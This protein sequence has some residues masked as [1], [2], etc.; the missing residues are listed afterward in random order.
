MINIKINGRPLRVRQHTTILDAAKAANIK[1]PTLCHLNLHEV[2]YYNSPGNCRVCMV[3]LGNGKLVPACVTQVTEGME[4]FSESVRVIKARRTIIELLLS[5]HP[6]SCLTCEKNT[7]CD[8][9]LLAH[10]LGV[11]EIK[12]KGEMRDHPID[13]HS[14][15]IVRDP[16]K[17]ILCMRCVT[18]CS[19]IQTVGA[20]TASDRGFDSKVGSSFDSPMQETTC[21]FCGQCLSICP[22]GALTEVNNSNQVWNAIADPDKYVV[23]QTAPAV[24]VALGEEFGYEVGTN[25]TGKM[26]AALRNLGVDRVYDTNFAADLTI[27]EEAAEFMRRLENGGTLPMIT[28]CCPSWVNFMEHSFPDMLDNPSSTKSPHEMFGAVA[29]TYLAKKLGIAPEKIYVVSVMP[30]VSKKFEAARDELRDSEL[31]YQVVDNVITTRELARMIKEAGIA[32]EDLPNEDFDELLGESTGAGTIFGATGGVLEATLR[33]CY[34]W[35]TGDDLTLL[36]FESL[37]GFSGVKAA[38]VTINGKELKF[39]V[40]NGLGNTRKVIEKIRAGE[41][42][43]DAIEVMACPG[44]CIGGAG[45]PYHHGDMTIL[46]KRSAAIYNA[47]KQKMIRKSNENPEVLALYEEY[48]GEINS[49]LAHELLHTTYTARPRH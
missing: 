40:C 32:F 16:N 24:R 42:H 45:Q 15:S 31:G 22:T 48:L 47:D 30:C 10:D 26:V 7:K 29:K 36:E 49:P 37:R 27:V 20:L 41:I 2:G 43:L 9:Q 44:G 12:Y 6:N 17:C 39:A 5:D 35:M 21:T 23:V 1:L 38:S 34:Q 46:S 11:R 28:S 8:L 3:E 33:T 14:L 25:V 19:D 13:T 4:I 18:M